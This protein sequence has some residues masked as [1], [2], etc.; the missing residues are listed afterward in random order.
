[1]Q[2]MP[3]AV[4]VGAKFMPH[5]VAIQRWLSSLSFRV[6]T[7]QDTVGVELGGALKNPLAV[8]AVSSGSMPSHHPDVAFPLP[9][10]R[11]YVAPSLRPAPPQGMIEGLG[12]GIN[13]M[14]ALV[15]RATKELMKL[16]TAMGGKAET[17]SGLAGIGDLMLTAFGDLSRN[18][19]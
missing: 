11:R 9:L 1:M 18:V 3:T 15:T 2:E 8:G 7:T 19:S 6:Y 4:V 12:L 17:I 5:A 14:A 16:C 10:P 13:T